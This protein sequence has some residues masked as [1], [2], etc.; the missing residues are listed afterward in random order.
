MKAK[1]NENILGVVG[2]L[3]PLASAEFLKTIYEQSLG[4]R[5]QESPIVMMYSDPTFPDRTSEFLKDSFDALLERLIGALRSLKGL[6][7][8]K[9]VICCV[10]AHHLLPRIPR[11]EREQVISLLDVI[12]K[13]VL[14]SRAKHL[15]ICSNGSRKMGVFQC[16]EK[17]EQA[18]E[19]IALP[20]D[21]D[22]HFIH[23]L[24]YEHIKRNGDI[25]RLV[26]VIESLMSKYGVKSFIAGCTEMHLLAKQI[27]FSGVGSEGYSCLDPLSIIAKEIAKRSL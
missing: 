11:E 27:E 5:E 14:R 10:T 19:F 8:S 26:P 9:T 2:G 22:Q 16:H 25:R 24:I 21:G 3:G 12:F 4:A 20:N 17:W 1:S 13:S 7:V 6:G 18:K 15:L 23:S